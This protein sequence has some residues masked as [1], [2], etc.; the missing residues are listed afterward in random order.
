MN[1]EFKATID[2]AFVPRP[3]R[4]KPR[5]VDTAA[6]MAPSQTPRIAKLI[7]L[8]IHMDRLLREGHVKDQAELAKLAGVTRARVTQVMNLLALAP[9]IQEDLLNLLHST[10]GTSPIDERQLRPIVA[11]IRWTEQRGLWRDRS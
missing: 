5:A 10:R 7:A 11:C 4:G 3:H 1:V 8:A 6:D 9:E 2:T